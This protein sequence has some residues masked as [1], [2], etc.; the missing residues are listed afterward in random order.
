MD[1]DRLHGLLIRGLA[2]DQNAYHFFLKELSGKLR[3]FFRKRLVSAPAEVEDLVQESLIAIHKLRHTYEPDQPLAAWV[4]AI[5]RYK[6]V[7]LL[8]RRARRESLNQ[9][10]DEEQDVLTHVDT[11]ALEARC[12]VTKLLA[13]LPAGQ[14]LAITH[15][16][17]QGLTIR[18]AA[19][20]CGMSESAVKVNIHRGLCKLAEKLRGSP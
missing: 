16:K 3:A 8:R 9:P 1:E 5:A 18:E 19:D 20:A 12:D 6:W 11:E 15:V 10:L 14:R 2:G 13:Q 4:Y 17:L 7:D